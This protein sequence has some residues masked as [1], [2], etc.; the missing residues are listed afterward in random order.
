MKRVQIV[1]LGVT[2]QTLWLWPSGFR[3]NPR[4]TWAD[5]QNSLEVL[6]PGKRML[7]YRMVQAASAVPDTVLNEI[8]RLRL[9]NSYFFENKY[10]VGQGADKDKRLSDDGRI[11]VCRWLREDIDNK[12][13]LTREIFINEYC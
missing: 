11:S 1:Q 3:K 2:W 4:G 7:A 8:S 9:P 10:F 13:G 6:Y 12:K 5:T